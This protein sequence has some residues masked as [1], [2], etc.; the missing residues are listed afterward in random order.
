MLFYS[1]IIIIHHVTHPTVE[2]HLNNLYPTSQI[3]ARAHPSLRI[4]S[5]TAPPPHPRDA[6]L[7]RPRRL[8]APP[9]HRVAGPDHRALPPANHRATGRPSPRQL[10]LCIADLPPIPAAGSPSMIPIAFPP[11]PRRTRSSRRQVAAAILLHRSPPHEVLPSPGR[12]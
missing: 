12:R 2:S 10:S 3:S 9:P 8:A 7:S 1:F 5:R 6:R 4:L 11:P